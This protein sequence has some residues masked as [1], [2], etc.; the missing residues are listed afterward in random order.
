VC[1]RRLGELTQAPRQLLVNYPR[2][3]LL[4]QKIPKYIG[5]APV[6]KYQYCNSSFLLT[7]INFNV[8]VRVSLRKD[9][10]AG[11]RQNTRG[12][13]K[14]TFLG[15]CRLQNREFCKDGFRTTFIHH[16]SSLLWDHGE[17]HSGP[18]NRH[19]ISARLCDAVAESRKG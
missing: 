16:F 11:Q 14:V 4:A 3:F 6:S 5:D 8:A 10:F 2:P 19:E 1:C 17:G 9:K 13:T 12:T 15:G 18:R 7:D